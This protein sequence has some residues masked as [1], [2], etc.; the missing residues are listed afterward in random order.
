[1]MFNIDKRT[2][3]IIG[4]IIGAV[5]C[6][7]Y[8]FSVDFFRFFSL[9]TLQ[10][11]ARE[12]SQFVHAH[13]V[14]SVLLYLAAG[15]I[16]VLFF[17]PMVTIYMLTAGFLFGPWIGAFYAVVGVTVGALLVCMLIRSTFG[18]WVRTYEAQLV[19]IN[20]FIERYGFYAVL[21]LRASH[22]VPFFYSTSLRH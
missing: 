8:F 11:H 5:V 4:V 13:Y 12:L 6:C 2:I 16:G 19:M 20:Q 1:M 22:L 15:I 9:E 17:L 18:R 7:I 14:L 21:L 10:C 3:G